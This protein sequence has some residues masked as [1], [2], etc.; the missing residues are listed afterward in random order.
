VASLFVAL[1]IPANAQTKTIKIGVTPGPHAQIAGEVAALGAKRGLTIQI[2]EISDYAVP[3]QAL[4]AGEL[5]ANSFQNAPYLDDQINAHGYKLVA[6]GKTV[7]VPMGIYAK[8]RKH[9][10]DLRDGAQIAIPNDPTNEF[11]ALELLQTAKLI[12]LRT[13][14]NSSALT[15]IV[16]NPKHLQIREMNAAQTVHSLDD[17]DAACV[18]GNYA[19]TAGLVP[20]RDA[21]FS[22]GGGEGEASRSPYSNIIVVRAADRNAAWAKELVALY[23]SGEIRAFILRHFGGSI[24]PAF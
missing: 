19:A 5:D 8:K 4:A 12:R 1:S 13:D 18:N 14:G 24:Y 9:L 6:I 11:R 15:D 16:E 3:N 17:L 22:E 10:A 2:V 7:L 20:N 23:Q 21:I